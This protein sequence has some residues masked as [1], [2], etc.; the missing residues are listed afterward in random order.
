M[1]QK[2]ISL[3]FPAACLGCRGDLA[4]GDRPGICGKCWKSIKTIRRLLCQR[5]GLPLPDGGGRCDSCRKRKG[6]G[7][8]KKI[9]S[10]ALYEG[11][12]RE[13][14]KRFKYQ[15]KSYLTPAWG[16]LLYQTAAANPEFLSC[17]HIIP[18]PVRPFKRWRRGYNP[19]ELIARQ[20]CRKTGQRLEN[21]WL[22][23]TR[24]RRSQTGLSRKERFKNVEGAFGARTV[25]L[26]ARGDILL[27]DDVC[28]TGA[29]LE[30][31][32]KALK[33]AGARRIFALTLARELPGHPR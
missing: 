1:L 22:K 13:L 21:D 26:P 2:I 19:A 20:F 9:R 3:I 5:C 23:A 25:R 6:S 32:A 33:A 16:E 31:C 30:E 8:L 28:T 12:L 15:R 7:P 11:P 4:P 27:I 17:R 14:I 18:V 29:T 10:A 24:G